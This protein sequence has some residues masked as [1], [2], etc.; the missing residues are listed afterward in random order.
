MKY[1]KIYVFVFTYLMSFSALKAADEDLYTHDLNVA[2]GNSSNNKAG[3][4]VVD[5]DVITKIPVGYSFVATVGA[6]AEGQ[7]DT[8][9][10]SVSQGDKL[11]R[12]FLSESYNNKNTYKVA[13]CTENKKSEKI[14]K[15]L[16]KKKFK[17]CFLDENRDGY[18]DF[19]VIDGLK[20]STF[21]I[22]DIEKIP[23]LVRENE[24]ICE[25]CFMEFYFADGGLL[26]PYIAMS[27]T[28]DGLLINMTGIF[29]ESYENSET[30][31]NTNTLINI[32]RKNLP[33]Q[34]N[35]GVV[36]FKVNSINKKMKSVNLDMLQYN[37]GKYF[38]KRPLMNRIYIYT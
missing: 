16:L 3:F 19:Y 29:I 27:L 11:I 6:N 8:I 17:I 22:N 18:F 26:G 13:F 4:D 12:S 20:N 7:S 38:N 10:W 21:K 5:D 34:I 37:G 2:I 33:Q 24:Q 31:L 9:R 25:K 23:Y 1:I 15:K 30:V 35:F 36:K 32:D 14:Y 28:L